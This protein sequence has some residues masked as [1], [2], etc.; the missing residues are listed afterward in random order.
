[1]AVSGLTS[2]GGRVDARLAVRNADG[3]ARLARQAVEALR[4][5]HDR[6]AATLR[7]RPDDLVRAAL[8]R[9][10]EV[11]DRL[12]AAPGAQRDPGALGDREAHAELLLVPVHLGTPGA[13]R[14]G[15]G[16]VAVEVGRH[17]AERSLPAPAHL[18]EEGA[19]QLVVAQ[20]GLV[21]RSASRPVVE[22]PGTGV[23]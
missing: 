1:M 12:R 6:V 10:D 4:A 5:Q 17:V 19:E 22:R 3:D 21:A 2:T 9:G 14:D 16:L 8:E 13:E 15:L 20:V 23:I 18:V 11:V 7:Q